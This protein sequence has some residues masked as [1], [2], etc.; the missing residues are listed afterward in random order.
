MKRCC[1]WS[2]RVCRGSSTEIWA[3]IKKTEFIEC[4]SCYQFLT[5]ASTLASR[6]VLCVPPITLF[7]A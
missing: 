7:L 6:C 4:L 2:S 5:K 1:V 3:T